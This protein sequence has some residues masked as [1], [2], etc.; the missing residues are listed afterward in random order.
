MPSFAHT[1]ELQARKNLLHQFRKWKKRKRKTFNVVVTEKSRRDM[2]EQEKAAKEKISR[3]K[4]GAEAA[5]KKEN[6]HFSKL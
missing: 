5:G 6:E 4:I 2:S 3:R 1:Q